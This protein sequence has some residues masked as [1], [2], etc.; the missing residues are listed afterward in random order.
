MDLRIGVE[1]DKD[2]MGA[3]DK[4][5]ARVKGWYLGMLRVQPDFRLHTVD[6]DS[7]TLTQLDDPK[8]FPY[9][10]PDCKDFFAGFRPLTRGGNLQLKVLASSKR[11]MKKVAKETEF[12]TMH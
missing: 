8:K 10:L 4:A 2:V 6:P 3:M 11:G 7:G 1:V 5:I 12:I 9:E